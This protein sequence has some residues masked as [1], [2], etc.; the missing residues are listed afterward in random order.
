MIAP[1]LIRHYGEDSIGGINLVGA[2]TKLGTDEAIS[3]LT[4][5]F[6]SLVPG[7]FATDVEESVRSLESLLRLCFAQEPSAEDLYLMLGTVFPFHPM[8]VRCCSL[9]RLTMTIGYRG[10]ASL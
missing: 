5:E 8:S 10:S 7:F 4:P 9:A 6:L 2:V 1:D 3:V